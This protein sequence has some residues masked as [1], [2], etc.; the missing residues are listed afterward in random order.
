MPK[1]NICTYGKINVNGSVF[2]VNK[3]IS[4]EKFVE[5]LQKEVGVF[6][7]Y[8]SKKALHT[9]DYEVSSEMTK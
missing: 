3:I 6:E 8:S 2:S 7:K 5:R 9:R 1:V 4:E